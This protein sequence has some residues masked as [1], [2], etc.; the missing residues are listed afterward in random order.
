MPKA[1]ATSSVCRERGV[2]LTPAGV[3]GWLQT[4]TC[5]HFINASFCLFL[6]IQPR[7]KME[8]YTEFLGSQ[9]P[10]S[11]CEKHSKQLSSQLEPQLTQV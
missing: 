6:A 1:C 9:P 11:E 10:S 4:R 5:L 8:A 3:S 2:G 7:E